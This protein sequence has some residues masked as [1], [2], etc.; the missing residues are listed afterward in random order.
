MHPSV[1]VRIVEGPLSLLIGSKDAN[2]GMRLIWFASFCQT[3]AIPVWT[4]LTI[5]RKHIPGYT[6]ANNGN[7][8]NPPKNIPVV[9]SWYIVRV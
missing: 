3:N 1:K 8:A 7:T 2:Q 5:I 4:H 9:N 6:K